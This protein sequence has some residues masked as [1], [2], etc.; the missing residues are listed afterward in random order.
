M[1]ATIRL[2]MPGC[3]RLICG[4]ASRPLRIYLRM[5]GAGIIKVTGAVMRSITVGVH[6]LGGLGL[7]MISMTNITVEVD[8][9]Y[10]L[11]SLVSSLVITACQGNFSVLLLSVSTL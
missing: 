6:S 11:V 2:G 9:L 3:R 7:T 4:I 8:L 1:V 10:V 5:M